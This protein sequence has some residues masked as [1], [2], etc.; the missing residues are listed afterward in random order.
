MGKRLGN[1]QMQCSPRLQVTELG[2][3]VV[4]H[5]LMASVCP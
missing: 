4:T 2:T 1:A 3:A 5:L